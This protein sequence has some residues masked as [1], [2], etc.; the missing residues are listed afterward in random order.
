MNSSFKTCIISST[1]TSVQEENEKNN[2][3]ESK[4]TDEQE[5][6]GSHEKEKT[7]RSKKNSAQDLQIQQEIDL[8]ISE[9]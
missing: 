8:T 1:D 6:E 9:N 4:T 7:T 5:I 3:A 2:H